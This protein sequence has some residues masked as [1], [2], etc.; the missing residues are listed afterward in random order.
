LCVAQ[1]RKNKNIDIIIETFYLHQLEHD[2]SELDLVIVGS[3][4]PETLKLQKLI[5]DYNLGG[6]VCFLQNISDDML[7]NLYQ[8]AS[9][10]VNASSIE[11]F[12]LPL[13]EACYYGKKCVATKI[14]VY[15]E[16]VKL[17]PLFSLEKTPVENLLAVIKKTLEVNYVKP[18]LNPNLSKQVITSRLSDLITTTVDSFYVNK[19]SPLRP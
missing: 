4:G 8:H 3:Q 2:V 19:N 11:G 18:I 1:H 16:L 7:V 15:E 17:V 9:L 5:E 14:P 10:I 6:K 12:G 13:I